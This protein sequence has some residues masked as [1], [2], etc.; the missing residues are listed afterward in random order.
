MTNAEDENIAYSLGEYMGKYIIYNFLPTLSCDYIKTNTVI[1]VTMGE[2]ERLKNLEDVWRSSY[3][4][5]SSDP[6]ET[7][8]KWIEFRDFDNSL[9]QKYLPHILECCLPKIYF[10]ES[11]LKSIKLGIRMSLWDSDCCAYEI[12][13]IEDIELWNIE[14]RTMLK[15]KLRI[16]K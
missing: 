9:E 1:Q 2:A 14:Y 4:D 12:E 10:N 6:I 5:K 16:N 11:D 8:K 13:N 3:Y 15:L 7:Q